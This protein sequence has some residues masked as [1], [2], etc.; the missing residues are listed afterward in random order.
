VL[1]A[2]HLS[3]GVGVLCDAK[4]FSTVLDIGLNGECG[5]L[6]TSHTYKVLDHNNK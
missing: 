1:P 5:K 4:L 6:A 3:V 2:L